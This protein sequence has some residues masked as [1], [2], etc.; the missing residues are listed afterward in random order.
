MVEACPA[1]SDYAC[2]SG[3]STVAAATAA[4]LLFVD[5]RL[6]AIAAVF[7]LLEGFSRVY[8]GAHYP[9]DVMASL[10]V[11]SAVAAGA[12]AA[13]RRAGNRVVTSWRTGGLRPLLTDHRVTHRAALSPAVT[14][15]VIVNLG[16]C[17]KRGRGRRRASALCQLALDDY[18]DIPEGSRWANAQ[19]Q[20]RCRCGTLTEA[21]CVGPWPTTGTR[22]RAAGW[23]SRH[24]PGCAGGRCSTG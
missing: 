3:H 20:A 24:R 8:L 12:A 9:H 18:A 21:R 14:G 23:R 15:S 1:P 16:D 6:A 22:R 17:G 13:G 11:G 4:A 10:L 19:R 7:A 5:R 2:P